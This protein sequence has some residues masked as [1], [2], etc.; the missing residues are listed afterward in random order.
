MTKLD[1]VVPPGKQEIIITRIF[2]APRALVFEAFTNPAL[3]PRWWGPRVMSTTVDKMEVR[4]GGIW[5]FL[6]REASGAEHGFHGVYH[7]A[8]APERLIYTFEWEGLPGHV[9]LETVTFEEHRGQ[10]RVTDT[11]VFQTLEDRDGMVANGMEGG[12]TESM[13]RMAEL[14]RTMSETAPSTRRV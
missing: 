11:S 14:L 5:R 8:V 9:L 7:D 2:A 13:D 1:V 4:P 10:T 3:I 6:N 12:A